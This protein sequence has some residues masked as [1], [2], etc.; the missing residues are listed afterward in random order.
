MLKLQRRLSLTAVEVWAWM[1]DYIPQKMMD[2]ITY[3]GPNFSKMVI[4]FTEKKRCYTA[5]GN[6]VM[7]MVTRWLFW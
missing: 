1:S 2:A 4:L 7:A 6:D 5:L 3:P